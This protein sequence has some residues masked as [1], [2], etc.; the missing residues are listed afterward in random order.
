MNV[1]EQGLGAQGRRAALP[2]SLSAPANFSV[3]SG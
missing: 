2:G 1:R 3:C